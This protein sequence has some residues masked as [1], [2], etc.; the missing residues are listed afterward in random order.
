MDETS[1]YQFHYQLFDSS[2][3][4]AGRFVDMKHTL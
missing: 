3:L 1:I 4:E 2:A